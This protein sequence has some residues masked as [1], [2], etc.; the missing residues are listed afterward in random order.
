MGDDQGSVGADKRLRVNARSLVGSSDD[1]DG[2]IDSASSSSSNILEDGMDVLHLKDDPLA[3][4]SIAENKT[5][6]QNQKQPQHPM[7]AQGLALLQTIFGP[8][9]SREELEQIHQ[10]RL[11][12]L[13]E[14]L[15]AEAASNTAVAGPDGG[16]QDEGR[17]RLEGD[18]DSVNAGNANRSRIRQ[19]RR[20]RGI[21][22]ALPDDFL[23]VPSSAMVLLGDGE[24]QC[25]SDLESMVHSSLRI[26]PNEFSREG[27]FFTAVLGRNA[28][29]QIKTNNVS[30]SLGMT[31]RQYEGVVCV[32]ALSSSKTSTDDVV[33][34][35]PAYDAG[36]RVG[37]E[38]LGV[39]GVA[40][41]DSSGDI[42]SIL[43]FVVEMFRT[44]PD[45]VVIHLRRG[46]G[47]EI[48]IVP[49][50]SNILI[51][52]DN[53]EVAI[54]SVLGENNGLS[55]QVQAIHP[56]AVLLRERG[57]LKTIGEEQ[58]ITQQIDE[59]T[60]RT[61]Q[62]EAT[63]TLCVDVNYNLCE[64]GHTPGMN[65]SSHTNAGAC[66]PS[67]P[68]RRP[69]RS[70]SA[71][72]FTSPAFASPPA[73]AK[74]NGS[75]RHETPVQTIRNRGVGYPGCALSFSGT[76]ANALKTKA[77]YLEMGAVRKGLCVRILNT[78][79]DGND[80]AYTIWVYDC[81]AEIE[82]YA[83]V[84]YFDDFIDLR[85][86]SV[87]LI[88]VTEE[89]PFPQK[90]WL[91][92]SESD[93][94]K[95]TK[96]KQ[97]EQFLRSLCAVT[98]KCPLHP[99]MVEL[100]IHV[101]SFLGCDTGAGAHENNLILNHQTIS[102]NSLYSADGV[103]DGHTN[104]ERLTRSKLK[105]S[106]QRYVYRVFLLPCI[107]QVAAQFVDSVQGEVPMLDEM[108]DLERRSLGLLKERAAKAL[109][110]TQHFIDS[111]QDLV[112]EGCKE[113]MLSIA[114]H[115]DYSSLR[116]RIDSKTGELY[117]EE[118]FRQAIR[119]HVEIEI[120]VPLRKA[121]STV[122]V[123]AWRHDDMSLKHKMNSLQARPQSYF[124]LHQQ[125]LSGWQSVIHI[126]KEGVGRSSLPCKKL[127]AIVDAAK[128]I[129]RLHEEERQTNLSQQ[130]VGS[131]SLEE[132]ME[133]LGADDFL[134]IFVF[135]IIMTDLERPCALCAL[136]EELCDKRAKISE[137]GYYLSSFQAAVTYIQEMSLTDK[138]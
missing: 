114:D 18:A 117:C 13:N 126:L 35:G 24:W 17:S 79:S 112:F 132:S 7:D 131:G 76:P 81:Q 123:N 38:I 98:Y 54:P 6:E 19:R 3:Q 12:S 29:K 110:K 86:A 92:I 88:K 104:M 97:L 106:I 95:E 128:E 91:P 34:S 82:F 100:A 105:A 99:N 93:V 60:E 55:Q 107:E 121:I 26:Q 33:W 124:D 39:N 51:D 41:P 67:T 77:R 89:F 45:P 90:N 113:D 8:D 56:L 20:R 108:R 116:D 75:M 43:P 44:T 37:D 68:V 135:C 84:R 133:K 47:H 119:E 49:E 4:P 48:S 52:A 30:G 102:N 87:R 74:H 65:K 21:D 118:L 31:L 50:N 28:A 61:R 111:F 40:V 62:W 57:I 22:V 63:S 14:S 58:S 127:R 9:A 23:T 42:E 109:A 96:R 36:I 2:D 27:E 94:V 103:D 138:I 130:E 15:A 73:G 11:G 80:T 83:P 78:F 137:V 46:D 129:Y 1:N 72:G 59:Y 16:N 32:H 122:L 69:R 125:S 25:T 101:Q 70:A 64:N 115:D 71:S 66:T 136:L 5:Q 10:T 53:R 120:Y 85:A 134:P